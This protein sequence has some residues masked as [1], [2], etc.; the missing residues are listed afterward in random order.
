MHLSVLGDNSIIDQCPLSARSDR[1][2]C[3]HDRFAPKSAFEN[4]GTANLNTK[5]LVS[6][7]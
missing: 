6:L 5:R 4:S 1:V 3:T 2:I 7:F